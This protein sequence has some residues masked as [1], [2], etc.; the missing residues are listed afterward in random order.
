VN[1][2]A[3]IYKKAWEKLTPE[4]IKYVGIAAQYR[5]DEFSAT[6]NNTSPP[7]WPA[8]LPK[9]GYGWGK[10]VSSNKTTATTSTVNKPVETY[11]T[12]TK[13]APVD[14]LTQLKDAMNYIKG[15]WVYLS[16]QGKHFYVPKNYTVTSL[17]DQITLKE[18]LASFSYD[19]YKARNVFS[20]RYSD[21]SAFTLPVTDLVKALSTNTNSYI[22]TRIYQCSGCLGRGG[23]WNNNTRLGA[24]CTTC[25][26]SGCVSSKDGGGYSNMPYA[27]FYY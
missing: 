7:A 8:G 21:G 9:P 6:Q 3:T 15:R 14:E 12:V 27:D 16:R 20:V 25:G 1:N 19:S 17:T 11:P 26:G 2:N 23:T 24:T 5:V 18:I 22:L 10:T 13:P 4:Q